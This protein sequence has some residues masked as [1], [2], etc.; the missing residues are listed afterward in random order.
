MADAMDSEPHRSVFAALGGEVMRLA[1]AEGVTP[2][3]F[4]GFDPEAFR[5]GDTGLLEDSM[6][7]MVAHN[8]NTAKTHSGI[9]RDLAVRKRKTEV[10][11]QMGI[12]VDIA[13]RH[14]IPT[15]A[16]T[17]LC[18]LIHDIED[19]QRKQSMELLDLMVHQCV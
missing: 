2:I 8:R 13:R 12:M 14:G 5:T 9:Y 6:D 19:G 15:P 4:N 3:G 18:T 1:A 16:L 10:D 17:M 7:A 11:A